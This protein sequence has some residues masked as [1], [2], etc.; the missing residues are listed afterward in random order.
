MCWTIYDRF[1]YNLDHGVNF[2]TVIKMID[3]EWNTRNYVFF[4]SFILKTNKQTNTQQNV[5]KIPFEKSKTENKN[6]MEKHHINHNKTDY[7]FLS[8]FYIL[9]MTL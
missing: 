7:V 6:Q 1:T 2:R 3:Y 4:L 8:I 5:T 9:S